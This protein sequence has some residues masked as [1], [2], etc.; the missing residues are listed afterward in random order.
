MYNATRADRAGKLD[1]V[2]TR[3]IARRRRQSPSPPAESQ[4][5]ATPHHPKKNG[6][7]ATQKENYCGIMTRF[8]GS[9]RHRSGIV[10]S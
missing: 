3:T 8:R 10:A 5:S 9:Y 1:A 4:F 6:Q 2:G 7:N